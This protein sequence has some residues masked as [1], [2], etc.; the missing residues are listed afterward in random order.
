MAKTRAAKKTAGRKMRPKG[1]TNTAEK[2]R[3][4][5]ALRRRLSGPTL[6]KGLVRAGARI[7]R[8]ALDVGLLLWDEDFDR[9]RLGLGLDRRLLRVGSFSR[10]ED[11]LAIDLGAVESS[12]CTTSSAFENRRSEEDEP[13]KVK[14]TKTVRAAESATPTQ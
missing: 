2:N 11:V 9:I 8:Q 6:E 13:G 3:Q 14:T 10:E 12:L 7:E 1:L 4:L 5:Y